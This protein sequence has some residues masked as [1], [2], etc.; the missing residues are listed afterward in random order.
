MIYTR[1]LSVEEMTKKKI[2]FIISNVNMGGAEV[3]LLNLCKG[4]KKS[5]IQ[6]EIRILTYFEGNAL[7]YDFEQIGI[8]VDSINIPKRSSIALILK[9]L[10]L[11]FLYIKK[12]NPDIVH[13]Q[14]LDTDRYGLIAAFFAGVKHRFSTVHNIELDETTGYKITRKITSIFATKIIFVAECAMN[15][16]C[17]KGIYPLEK[18]NRNFLLMPE[19]RDVE[20]YLKQLLVF[21]P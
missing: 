6:L 1:A 13:T 16:Y 5:N 11:S 17:T 7:K 4:I 20:Q 14:L 10:W 8:P 9:K 12:F 15:H 18:M 19:F 2:L 3:L 21:Q